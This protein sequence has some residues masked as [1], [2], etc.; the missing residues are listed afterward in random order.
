MSWNVWLFSAPSTD[1]SPW[2][3]FFGLKNGNFAKRKCLSFGSNQMMILKKLIFDENSK[4][5]C[6]NC[7]GRIGKS[8]DRSKDGCVE[9]GQCGVGFCLL[10]CCS[11]WKESGMALVS[12]FITF[13]CLVCMPLLYGFLILN[14]FWIAAVASQSGICKLAIWSS[15]TCNYWSMFLEVVTFVTIIAIPTLFMTCCLT[16]LCVALPI[17]AYW[18]MLS[19]LAGSIRG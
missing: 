19:I 12:W 4:M 17:L 7:F 3:N 6:E 5:S 9:I 16:I 13:G 14:C 2:I 8:C 10:P 18:F 1:V 15:L 11:N